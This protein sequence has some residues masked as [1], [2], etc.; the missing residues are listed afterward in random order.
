MVERNLW[1]FCEILFLI[2][3]LHVPEC[4]QFLKTDL[5]ILLAINFINEGFRVESEATRFKDVVDELSLGE[6]DGDHY[7]I[8]LGHLT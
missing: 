5:Y 2:N 3:C 1:Q 8:T 6:W 7:C 4:K